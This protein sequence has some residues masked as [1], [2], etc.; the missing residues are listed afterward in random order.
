MWIKAQSSK[1][2][3]APKAWSP[4][5]FHGFLTEDNPMPLWKRPELQDSFKLS[6]I[7]NTQSRNTDLIEP[8]INTNLMDRSSSSNYP[9]G[10]I[11]VDN[12]GYDIDPKGLSYY[13]VE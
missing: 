1:N 4:S 11:L 6:H 5:A 8:E 2:N 12:G 7:I 9:W 3:P 13:E 10:S